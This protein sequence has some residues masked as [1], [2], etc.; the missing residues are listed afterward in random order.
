MSVYSKKTNFTL[1]TYQNQSFNFANNSV[2][3]MARFKNPGLPDLI[4]QMVD[5]ED[6][7]DLVVHW[8]LL[9]SDTDLNVHIAHRRQFDRVMVTCWSNV[10]AVW[11]SNTQVSVYVE[12]AKNLKYCNSIEP[13]YAYVDMAFINNSYDIAYPGFVQEIQKYTINQTVFVLT[14]T[15]QTMKQEID[16]NVKNWYIQFMILDIDGNFVEN[17]E[18][19]YWTPLKINTINIHIYTLVG[20]IIATIFYE[21]GVSLFQKYRQRKLNSAEHVMK[22]IFLLKPDFEY[23]L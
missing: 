4:T 1:Q 19:D 11:N 6:L 2:Q 16:Y 20:C 17:M 9:V 7:A 8:T 5:T 10:S 14:T 15:N 18:L 13:K 22:K 23:D 21:I 3:Y 12:L